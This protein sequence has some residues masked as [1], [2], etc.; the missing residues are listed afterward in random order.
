MRILLAFGLCVTLV[1]AGPE[2]HKRITYE[3]VGETT[4]TS[5]IK[6]NLETSE[7][8]TSAFRIKSHVILTILPYERRQLEMKNVKVY[9]KSPQDRDFRESASESEMK[10]ALEKHHVEFSDLNG[11]VAK[12]IAPPDEPRWVIDIKRGVISAF[13]VHYQ[14]DY[15]KGSEDGKKDVYV[16][17]I[18]EVDVTGDCLINYTVTPNEKDKNEITLVKSKDP[19]DCS[20]H[21]AVVNCTLPGRGCHAM[22]DKFT[23]ASQTSIKL[24]ILGSNDDVYTNKVVEEVK[25]EEYVLFDGEMDKDSDLYLV[26]NTTVRQSLK[27]VAA[28]PTISTLSAKPDWRTYSITAEPVDAPKPGNIVDPEQ[29]SF[30]KFDELMTEY[31]GEIQRGGYPTAREPAL[32]MNLVKTLR[33]SSASKLLHIYEKYTSS[34]KTSR[35]TFSEVLSSLDTSVA[36]KLM[37]DQIVSGMVDDSQA[38]RYLRGIAIATNPTG[39]MINDVLVIARTKPFL[40]D[41]SLL[42]LG[43]MISNFITNHEVDEAAMPDAVEGA[44]NFLVS[45]FTKSWKENNEVNTLMGIKGLMNTGLSSILPLMMKCARECP[46]LETRSTAIYSP[47]KVPADK[48]TVEVMNEMSFLFENDTNPIE[49]R[50]AAFV[51]LMELKPS[52]EVVNRISPTLKREASVDMTN[53]ICTYLD[54]AKKSYSHFPGQERRLNVY[55]EVLHRLGDECPRDTRAIKFNTSSA[56]STPFGN[57]AVLDSHMIYDV[58]SPLPREIKL[59]LMDMN[60]VMGFESNLVEVGLRLEGVD[61][62]LR[63]YK[64]GANNRDKYSSPSGDDSLEMLI[65][66]EQ[67]EVSEEVGRSSSQCKRQILKPKMSFYVVLLGQEVY[68]SHK[69]IKEMSKLLSR[70]QAGESLVYNETTQMY[71]TALAM[72]TSLGLPF[73][74]RVD[75]GSR[76]MVS[77]TGQL[78]VKDSEMT[79]QLNSSFWA[80]ADGEIGVNGYL[81]SSGVKFNASNGFH[82]SSVNTSVSYKPLKFDMK[83]NFNDVSG[84]SKRFNFSSFL[85]WKKGEDE[86]EVAKNVDFGSL[87]QE[88]CI[89][90]QGYPDFDGVCREIDGSNGLNIT[91]RLRTG[92]SRAR[93]VEEPFRRLQLKL[94]NSDLDT[95]LSKWDETENSSMDE[96]ER[97][98]DAEYNDECVA[99]GASEWGRCQ[100]KSQCGGGY[101]RRTLQ[102]WCDQRHSDCRQGSVIESKPCQSCACKGRAEYLTKTHDG[103]NCKSTQKYLTCPKL[104]KSS[105]FRTVDVAFKCSP[106]EVSLGRDNASTI[107]LTKATAIP[108]GCVCDHEDCDRE[109]KYDGI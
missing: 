39:E 15:S 28:E 17:K 94:T 101:Q 76:F 61:P 46:T 71:Y 74:A 72:P 11:H 66:S 5:R 19:K 22:P 97:L 4:T 93:L 84:Y 98:P 55:D 92:A 58:N 32:F 53:Y 10:A 105:S 70:L 47:W 41:Q 7:P 50:V 81:V 104:C 40:R 24:R 85:R 9:E 52:I 42:T 20:R 60:D 30:P 75:R 36:V 35:D 67:D 16:Y 14:D 54:T 88:T 107:A 99:I 13:Q 109:T 87:H 69:D 6:L 37:A 12:V 108:E 77:M 79:M 80:H 3:Y 33:Q 102:V 57:E 21:T 44:K 68:F 64:N 25:L 65:S 63:A 86:D 90:V 82:H 56:S 103:M 83:V 91:Y 38:K 29:V 31:I 2:S 59:N 100:S 23:S 73:T 26:S 49:I 95:L 106:P 18:P 8:E 89:D 51:M 96:K 43:S 27:L 78:N 1:L 48:I 62:L 34:D 45:F